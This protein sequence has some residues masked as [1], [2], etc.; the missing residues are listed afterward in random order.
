M[1]KKLIE[2]MMVMKEVNTILPD[3]KGSFFVTN[4]HQDCE[5]SKILVSDKILTKIK[6]LS[7]F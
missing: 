6:V 1:G 2:Q 7:L 5:A 4:G 3:F